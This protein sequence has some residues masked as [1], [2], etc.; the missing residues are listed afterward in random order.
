M[1]ISAFPLVRT[2]RKIKVVGG[3]APFKVYPNIVG[4]SGSTGDSYNKSK[5]GL[6]MRQLAL[7]GGFYSLP[8]KV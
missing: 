1:V 3:V 2:L 5:L 4:I 7:W 8:F 6:M